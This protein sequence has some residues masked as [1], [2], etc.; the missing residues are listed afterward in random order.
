M[1]DVN[2]LD[3]LENI[4]L[5]DSDEVFN[6]GKSKKGDIFKEVKEVEKELEEMDEEELAAYK[7]KMKEK[8]EGEEEEDDDEDEGQSYILNDY[9]TS[10]IEESELIIDDMG[11]FEKDDYWTDDE[12]GYEGV[13]INDLT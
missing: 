2:E 4:G 10:E 12:E 1:K 13:D 5:L 9:G 7:K 6:E 3:D 8:E 11:E